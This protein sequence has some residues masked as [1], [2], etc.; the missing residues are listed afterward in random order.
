L[1]PK[2]IDT[3]TSYYLKA[4][5]GESSVTIKPVSKDKTAEIWIENLQVPNGKSLT[6]K[7]ETGINYIDIKVTPKK[8]YS[9][10]YR[11]RVVREAQPNYTNAYLT[12]IRVTTARSKSFTPSFSST[13]EDYEVKSIWYL[14]NPKIYVYPKENDSAVYIDGIKKRYKSIRLSPGQSKRV[15]I[16]VIAYDG[17]SKTYSVDI[18]KE[19]RP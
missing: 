15:Y 19:K 17:T 18:E 14:G 8:G 13:V 9:K 1:S 7:L 11:L 16:R 12:N 4:G 2:F 3:K 6:L 10:T 5:Y